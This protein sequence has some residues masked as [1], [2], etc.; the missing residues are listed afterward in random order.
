SD[1]NKSG[2]GDADEYTW[3]LLD[4]TTVISSG[5]LQN[6]GSGNYTLLLTKSNYSG[7]WDTS[8]NLK[9]SAYRNGGTVPPA[10]YIDVYIKT[11]DT[12]LISYN[13]VD[14]HYDGNIYFNYWREN[15][16]IGLEYRNTL[17]QTLDLLN[18]SEADFK[19]SIPGLTP[20]LNY[21]YM[22]NNHPQGNETVLLT[23]NLTNAGIGSYS[24]NID[25]NSTYYTPLHFTYQLRVD[26]VPVSI[27][28]DS[29]SLFRVNESMIRGAFDEI[30]PVY[31]TLQTVPTQ[32]FS[33]EPLVG[34]QGT[35]SWYKESQPI[36]ETAN[37]GY[38]F[39]VSLTD[40]EASE[41]DAGHY[42]LTVLLTKKNYSTIIFSFQLD[43]IREWNTAITIVEKN[44]GFV[45]GEPASIT[46]RFYCNLAPRTNLGLDGANVS[47]PSADPFSGGWPADKWTL[48]RL[49]N[50]L[51]KITYETGFLADILN[52]TGA[53]A[54][55]PEV[56]FALYHYQSST[57]NVAF[58]VTTAPIGPSPIMFIIIAGVFAAAVPIGVYSYRYYQWAK[59]P[60]VVKKI[61]KTSDG[62]KKDEIFDIVS[63]LTRDAIIKDKIKDM[64]IGIGTASTFAGLMEAAATTEVKMEKTS[65]YDELNKKIDET[66]P[67]I[68]SSEKTA[69]IN[70]LIALPPEEREFLLQSFIEEKEGTSK[71][72]LGKVDVRL[73]SA[74][75][76]P[77]KPKLVDE[78]EKEISNELDN[79]LKQG[80]ITKE[81]KAVLTVELKELSEKDRKLFLDRLKEA[82]K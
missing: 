1:V 73:K 10:I 68:T 22:V 44:D 72:T 64:F 23:L 57:E 41:I 50:G 43:L 62:I 2:I 6:S 67:Y 51:Y 24:L 82:K 45:I 38:Q 25:V 18:F 36:N 12:A 26:P 40:L 19:V 14:T 37:G 13:L 30:I 77:A 42:T 75:E 27:Q 11:W 53:I 9:I 29:D 60:P 7:Y 16:T 80:I 31:L 46:Y 5:N 28:W 78:L 8:L 21:T 81:E 47:I 34:C 32:H 4:G 33:A 71:S 63:P 52:E 3:Q 76:T 79:L 55:Q 20:N 49:G 69:L 66:L 39:M 61:I 58:A 59:L 15:I 48:E 65:L 17:N 74:K 70:E 54:F 35:F 56:V